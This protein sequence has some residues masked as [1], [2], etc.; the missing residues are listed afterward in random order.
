[1][2]PVPPRDADGLSGLLTGGLVLGLSLIGLGAVAAEAPTFGETWPDWAVATMALAAPFS[3]AGLLSLGLGAGL[4]TGDGDGGIAAMVAVGAVEIALGVA[5]AVAALAIAP[6]IGA[7]WGDPSA[8]ARTS[9]IL[10]IEALSLTAIGL[11]PVLVAAGEGG[12]D[13]DAS[14]ELVAAPVLTPT[15]IGV[16]LGGRF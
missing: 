9:E 16:Q 6:G 11:V 12:P 10:A 8:Q 1:M 4:A 2:H 15:A 3:A 14:V 13:G 5:M 7:P